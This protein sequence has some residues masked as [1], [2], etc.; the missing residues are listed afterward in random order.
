MSQDFVFI[1]GA[2]GG[3]GKALALEYANN[4]Y[5]IVLSGRNENKLKLLQKEL[6]VQTK[7]HSLV[8]DVSN[9]EACQNAHKEI[10]NLGINIKVLINNA[11]ITYI[12][13][14]DKEYSIKRY[15]ELIN[16]N[17]NGSVYMTQIFLEELLRNKGS[18]INISSVIGYAPV[19]GRSAYAASKYGLDGFFSV[20][21]AETINKLHIMMVYPTFI[22]T[23]IREGLNINTNK[24]EVLTAE[25]VAQK[26]AQAH[27]KKKER[28][29]IGNTAKLTYYLYKY[30]PKTYVYLM[31]KKVEL[32]IK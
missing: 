28:V 30:F 19:V 20:L 31:R 15:Q 10:K 8:C 21:Q 18:I 1:T 26:V 11:G 27:R 12:Q 16:T 24:Y 6:E 5:G 4:G 32:E 17:L 29:Y 7:V 2:Y 14:F 3:L 23:Q 9:W 13:K 22:A 25:K